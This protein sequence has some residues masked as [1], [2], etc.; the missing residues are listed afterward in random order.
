MSLSIRSSVTA[1]VLSNPVGETRSVIGRGVLKN[2]FLMHGRLNAH[3]AEI[4]ADAAA[5]DALA[6]LIDQVTH[7]SELFTAQGI[8]RLVR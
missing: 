6:T 7:I 3:A 8:K 1:A 5:L 2:G 4:A